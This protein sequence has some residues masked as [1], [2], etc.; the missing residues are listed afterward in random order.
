MGGAR[1]RHAQPPSRRCRI[2]DEPVIS[3]HS[4]GDWDEAPKRVP[5][6]G[7]IAFPTR[8]ASGDNHVRDTSSERWGDAAAASLPPRPDPLRGA[9]VLPISGAG[10]GDTARHTPSVRV[11]QGNHDPGDVHGAPPGDGCVTCG[12]QLAGLGANDGV[13]SVPWKTGLTRAASGRTETWGCV[14]VTALTSR[15]PRTER[16]SRLR[17]G[18]PAETGLYV[19]V[20]PPRLS[21]RLT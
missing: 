6:R 17:S 3:P 1:A 2:P 14:L 10:G 7:W 16:W 20:W 11:G 15:S 19:P 21:L 9:R 5:E 4:S 18:R 13:A 8:G 12:L